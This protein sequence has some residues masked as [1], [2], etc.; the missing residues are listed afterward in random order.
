[1][2][3]VHLSITSHHSTRMAKHMIAETA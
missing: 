3:S 1:M 2:Q